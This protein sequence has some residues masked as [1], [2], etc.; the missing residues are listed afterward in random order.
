[1]SELANLW[2]GRLPLA[3]AFWKHAVLIGLAVN[4]AATVASL[5]AIAAGLS[6][7]LALALHLAP[8]PYTLV[9]AAGVW[10]SAARHPGPPFWPDMARFAVLVW[11]TLLVLV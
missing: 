2:A 6:S 11:A 10:R 8:L 7:A 3:Q 5:G 4:L 9:C 1:L